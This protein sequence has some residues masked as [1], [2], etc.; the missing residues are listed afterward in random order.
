VARRAARE[1]LQYLTGVQEFWSL[2]FH[3]TPAVLIPRPETEAI[4]ETFLRLNRRPDP[5]VLDVGTGSGC[6]AVAV[7]REVPGARVLACD[8]S[9][10]ALAVARD[11]AGRHGVADRIRFERGDLLDAFRP[12]GVAGQADFILCNPPYVPEGALAGL[13]PEVRDHEPRAALVA[14]SDG[15]DVHR[16]LAAGAA[17]FLRPA[18]VDGAGGR[19]IVEFGF[20]QEAG[21]RAVYAPAA[22]WT[23]VEVRADLAGIPRL[24][25]LRAAG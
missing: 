1:P 6:L 7:A 17:G 9:E 5:L 12:A 10:G 15:L 19:L 20:G 3:V 8:R 11:N 23:V 21:I 13:S 16:R 14:G 4:V 25:V 2:S 22:G 18:G 24:A